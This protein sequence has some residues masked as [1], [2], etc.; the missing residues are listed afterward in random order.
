MGK[1]SSTK[2]VARAARTGGGRTSRGSRTSL[3]WPAF[4][5]IVVVLGTAGIVY[6]K[7]QRA[8]DT[9]RPRAGGN[10]VAGDHWHAAIGIDVCGTFLP[11]L[12]DKN[13][14]TL[15]IHTHGEGIA[16]IHPFSTVA[17]GNRATLKVFFDMVGARVSDTQMTVPGTDAKKNGQ[18]CG[19]KAAEIQV[20][21]WPN[22]NPDT[23]G[24][25]IAVNPSDIRP[26]DGEL[27]TIAFVP[28]GD[29]IPRPPSADQLDKLTD[30]GAQSTTTIP[31]DTSTT[32]P[33]TTEPP[34]TTTS[35]P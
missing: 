33:P 21:T 26:K 19:D 17:S 11:N 7:D 32:V 20:K 22:K 28:K 5:G 8:P 6:S 24:T 1:A 3:F 10:G 27:I 4:I 9:T 31:G 16:H 23:N 35:V 13:K 25:V 12:T 30:V 34:A 29:D 18:K 2:K 15:G 14:D